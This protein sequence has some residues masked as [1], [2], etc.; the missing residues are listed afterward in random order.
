MPS[1]YE[2]MLARK[3]EA[4]RENPEKFK[5]R[6][7]RYYL[8]NREK[9]MAQTRAYTAARPGASSERNRE[10]HRADPRHRL[11]RSAAYRAAKKG[12]EFDLEL[13]DIV[14]PDKCP[15]LGLTFT[16]DGGRQPTSYSLD[17]VHNDQ[18]YV[19]GNVLV[20]SFRANMVKGDATLEEIM[21]VQGYMVDNQF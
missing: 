19:R 13:K 8:A 5:A 4:Y 6:N 14:L 16:V 10:K 11:L 15:V 17:R 12:L 20:I 7:R 21:A 9:L 2:K 18:G 3:R 1:P